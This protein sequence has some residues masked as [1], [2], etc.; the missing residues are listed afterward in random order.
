MLQHMLS[1]HVQCSGEDLLTLAIEDLE[2]FQAHLEA[3]ELREDNRPPIARTLPGNVTHKE[4]EELVPQ[5][6]EGEMKESTSM[7]EIEWSK[8]WGSS[9]PWSKGKTAVQSKRGMKNTWC[10]F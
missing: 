9:P 1:R 4:G 7:G 10:S 6:L 3:A 2:T 5:V 8:P